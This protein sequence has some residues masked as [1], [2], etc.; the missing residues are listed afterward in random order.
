MIASFYFWNPKSAV[1]T[2][3][4]LATVDEL[5]ELLIFLWQVHNLPILLAI[6][7]FMKFAPTFYTVIF[8]AR[9]TFVFCEVVFNLKD[10]WTSRS[11]APT[12][13]AAIFVNEDMEWKFKILVFDLGV[14]VLLNICNGDLW[15]AAI[16]RAQD[17]K[18]F[19]QDFVFEVF[20]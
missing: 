10:S 13:R 5:H 7:A 6:H 8:L 9:H 18:T 11:W 20:V 14:N 17:R 4:E 15:K 12:C 2:L 1:W 19:D 16:F 3:L